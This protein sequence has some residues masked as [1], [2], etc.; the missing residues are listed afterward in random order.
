MDNT[1]YMI[2]LMEMRYE[3]PLVIGEPPSPR[4]TF[5]M[6]LYQDKIWIYGGFTE[7]VALNDLYSLDLNNWLWKK[8]A[9]TGDKPLVLT[10][11][12][13]TKVGKKLYL[14]GGCDKITQKCFNQTYSINFDNY[15][16]E[17]YENGYYLKLNKQK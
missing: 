9:T 2:N 7:T 13:S 11:G 8:I 6:S 3:R 15:K 5:G 16:W 1:V 10:G 12:I 14:T 4:Q 17:K